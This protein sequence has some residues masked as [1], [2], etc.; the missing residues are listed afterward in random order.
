MAS[1][2]RYSGDFAGLT[3]RGSS[4]V[5]GLINLKVCIVSETLQNDRLFQILD[6]SYRLTKEDYAVPFGR[7]EMY[8]QHIGGTV[9]TPD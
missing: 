3:S 1:D 7:P 9:K 6:F 2:R 5:D 8:F 4:I